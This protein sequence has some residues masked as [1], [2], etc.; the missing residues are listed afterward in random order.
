MEFYSL[1]VTAAGG[2]IKVAFHNGL[3]SCDPETLLREVKL[4]E[5]ERVRDTL[6]QFLPGL[7]ECAIISEVC[8]Y[9]MTHDGH[10]YLGRRPGSSNVFGAAFAGHGFKFAPV[11]GE[12]LA[13]M[14]IDSSPAF[15]LSLFSPERFNSEQDYNF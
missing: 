10:F 7:R 4:A 3:D 15:D 6:S 1:P 13:D 12:I 11:L 14:L 8:L 5:V 9:T 2:R